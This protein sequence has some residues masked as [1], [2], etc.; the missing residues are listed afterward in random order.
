MTC[1]AASRIPGS[2]RVRTS[3]EPDLQGKYNQI[4]L[5]CIIW[6]GARPAQKSRSMN[7]QRYVK[8]IL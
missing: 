4:H 6:Q 8:G 7:Q 1:S 3:K 5:L 2:M